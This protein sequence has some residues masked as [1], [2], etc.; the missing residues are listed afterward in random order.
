MVG[1]Q[2][3]SSEACCA[4]H[5]FE[6]AALFGSQT[7][8][9]QGVLEKFAGCVGVGGGDLDERFDER[10]LVLRVFSQ[11]ERGEVRYQC[12]RRPSLGQ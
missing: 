7:G 10:T 9:D 8:S 12:A 6:A 2:E 1:R 4:D 3:S 11:G 5:G